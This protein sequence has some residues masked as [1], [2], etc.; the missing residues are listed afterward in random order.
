MKRYSPVPK[1]LRLEMFLEMQIEILNG[2][3]ILVNYTFKLN[4]NFN[5]NL[6]REI[7]RILNFLILT[8]WLKC[9]GHQHRGFRYAFRRAFRTYQSV[10]QF[11]SVYSHLL[12]RSP[13]STCL[14]NHPHFFLECCPGPGIINY[15]LNS[16]RLKPST[17]QPPKRAEHAR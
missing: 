15:C 1:K 17:P 14:P 12:L 7:L 16:C 2:G 4:Q 11:S 6:C 9:Y 10:V 5:S 3:E 13:G 8:T